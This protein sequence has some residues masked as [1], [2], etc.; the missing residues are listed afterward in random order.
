M[1]VR[2]GAALGS[3]VPALRVTYG[4]PEENARFLDALGEV[5]SPRR[6]PTIRPAAV[7]IV[8]VRPATRAPIRGAAPN[9]LP[10][11]DL[12]PAVCYKP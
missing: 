4:L 12:A 9:C 7:R 3:A 2:G 6:R 8:A 1:L 5:L 11:L 10:S